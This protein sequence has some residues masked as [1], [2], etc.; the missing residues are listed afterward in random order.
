M[1]MILLKS[2]SSVFMLLFNVKCNKQKYC[3]V[4]EHCL[5]TNFWVGKRYTNL[6]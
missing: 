3:T 5:W 6:F 4:F 2:H 1:P